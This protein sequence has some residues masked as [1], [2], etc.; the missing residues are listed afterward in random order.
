MKKFLSLSICFILL[1]S[2]LSGCAQSSAAEVRQAN[3]TVSSS[4]Q[5]FSTKCPNNCSSR[6]TDDDGLY[7]YTEQDGS[8]P[9]ILIW[10]YENISIGSEQFLE[11]AIY[12]NMAENYGSDLLEVSPVQNYSIGGKTLPGMLF[13]Y[14]ANGYTIKSLRL[15]FQSGNDLINFTAKYL[16]GEE[17]SVTEALEMAMENF[18]DELSSTAK[19]QSP[20]KNI[21]Q[22]DATAPEIVV[23]PSENANVSYVNYSDPSG[24]F[25]LEIPEGWAVTVGLPPNYEVDLISYALTVYDPENLD[26]RFYFNLCCSGMLKSE[27]AREWYNTY[28]ANTFGTLPVVSDVS[29]A[30]FFKALGEYYGYQNFTVTENIGKTALNGDLLDATAVSSY[31]GNSIRGLFTAM[32][33]ETNSI[34]QRN[35]FDLSQGTIDAG[36]LTVYSVIYEVAPEEEFLDWQPV[37]NHC[38][39][40]LS[41]TTSFQSQ[42]QS[43]WQSVLGTSSYLF[44]T[45]EE[46][47][48]M[49]M[50]TWETRNTSYD[51]ISQKQSD[52]TLGYERV[53]DTE[54]GEYYMT[55]AGF[56]D[57]FDSSRYVVVYDD[58]AYL[59]PTSGW[60]DWKT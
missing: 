3:Q 17:D 19:S 56:D 39:E 42:R 50:D 25:T 2:L 55:D 47:S 12:A 13:T 16:Q 43:Q 1:F 53:L 40:S 32:V 49:I 31:T 44:N 51:I 36:F 54:T 8:I 18:T 11:E 29:T 9:Y 35:M 48:D 7:I 28:Y 24:Y 23:Y 4:V 6:W 22:A 21:T 59:S 58:N 15:V 46:I 38:F 5:Q 20:E 37:L 30:G 41:F 14:Q 52:A 26:R 10:R 45:A 60:I 57:A 27:E 33:T 34:V